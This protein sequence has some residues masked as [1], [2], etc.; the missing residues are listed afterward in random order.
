MTQNFEELIYFSN[1][2][3]LNYIKG[4][5][6]LTEMESDFEL[7]TAEW[8][9][10]KKKYKLSPRQRECCYLFYWGQCTQQEVADSLGIS[11]R[12][13][14]THLK[15]SRDRIRECRQK[16]EITKDEKEIQN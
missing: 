11:R 4:P 12:S 7:G 15:R 2:E 16:Q 6:T 9:V 10:L 5:L 14:R 13:V 3:L 1:R 8:D